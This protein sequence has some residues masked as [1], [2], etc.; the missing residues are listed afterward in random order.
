[1]GSEFLSWVLFFIRNGDIYIQESAAKTV[2]CLSGTSEETKKAMGDAGFL[3]ELVKLLDS[4][5]SEIR[6]L[7]VKALLNMV[8]I[9]RN[10]KRFIQENS[11]VI[12]V[13]QLLDPEDEKS[14]NKKLLLSLLMSL[15]NSNT[16]RRKIASS[17]Y[18]K[19]LEKLAGAGVT[20]AK[21]IIKKLSENRFRTILRGILNA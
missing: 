19:N 11:N 12:R 1:M 21:R 7:A 14:D 4:K 2:F 6:E 15:T 18:N 20:D 5:S 3:V 10:Q 8:S 16:A 17:I 13:L 9:P